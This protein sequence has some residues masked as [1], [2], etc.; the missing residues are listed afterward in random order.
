MKVKCKPDGAPNL[1]GFGPPAAADPQPG[2]VAVQ[3]PANTVPAPEATHL[4]CTTT[5]REHVF[6]A[7][8]NEAAKTQLPLKPAT[9][10]TEVI[11]KSGEK[12]AP[13]PCSLCLLVGLV[14]CANSHPMQRCHAN[15]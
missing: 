6:T 14:E 7:N 13:W 9:Y 2:A 11:N 4:C 3:I 12:L 5:V 1:T 10:D 8:N 15:P